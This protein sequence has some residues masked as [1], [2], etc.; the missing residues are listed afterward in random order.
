MFAGGSRIRSIDLSHTPTYHVHQSNRQQ[1][2]SRQPAAAGRSDRPNRVDGGTVPAGVPERE[3]SLGAGGKGEERR[4]SVNPSTHKTKTTMGGGGSKPTDIRCVYV[5]MFEC[6]GRSPRPIRWSKR[7]NIH[8]LAPKKI[9]QQPGEPP[10]TGA[11][12][13][14][15]AGGAAGDGGPDAE[16]EGGLRA[17]Q[18]GEMKRLGCGGWFCWA[19]GGAIHPAII[20]IPIQNT[21]R[22]IPTTHHHRDS[23]RSTRGRTRRWT[24]C[25]APSP[26]ASSLGTWGVRWWIDN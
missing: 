11:V 9:N 25:A 17:A 5:C 18:A 3:S 22:H 13:R 26:P 7:S 16:N 15:G 21:P 10:G 23:C 12:L 6:G 8:S 19:C 20:C 1:R 24:P 2:D 14:G 4:A